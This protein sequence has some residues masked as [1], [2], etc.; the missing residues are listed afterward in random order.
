MMTIVDETFVISCF[1]MI[2]LTVL[3]FPI[4]VVGGHIMITFF[5]SCMWH[6]SGV[7]ARLT[8]Y[9]GL[10]LFLAQAK[11]NRM[12]NVHHDDSGIRATEDPAAPPSPSTSWLCEDTTRV[13]EGDACP[14]APPSPI[15]SWLCED[16]LGVGDGDTCPPGTPPPS[17]HSE[18]A[19]SE[20]S[21]P[22]SQAPFDIDNSVCS[23]EG[24]SGGDTLYLPPRA[25]YYTTLPLFDTRDLNFDEGEIVD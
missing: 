24:V 18:T 13:G 20:G 10:K 22:L 8:I 11:K 2:I 14:P 9:S 6:A 16:T 15:T 1:Y 21:H 5:F 4:K 12:K 7:M 19:S 25:H 17:P 23:D 3:C